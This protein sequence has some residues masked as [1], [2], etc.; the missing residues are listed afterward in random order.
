MH[1]IASEAYAAMK[2]HHEVAY[3]QLKQI[4]ELVR[5]EVDKEELADAAF[6]LKMTGDLADDIRKMAKVT[7]ELAEKMCCAKVLA[8]GHTGTINTPFMRVSPDIKTMA[9]VPSKR[10]DPDAYEK[11]MGHLGIR[12]DLLKN[13]AVR[14]HWPG[15]VEYVSECASVGRPLPP[16]VDPS[17]TYP[18]YRLARWRKKKEPDDLG[19]D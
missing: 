13:D 16:G 8:E 14:P 3:R 10:R 15:L 7:Q 9:A 17:S 4:D 18:V 12:E 19:E 2:A 1:K 6:A 5:G 11:L